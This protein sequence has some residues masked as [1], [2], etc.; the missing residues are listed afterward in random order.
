MCNTR[1]SLLVLLCDFEQ[2]AKQLAHILKDVLKFH[3]ANQLFLKSRTKSQ[4]HMHFK[5]F[6]EELDPD[7]QDILYLTFHQF[8]G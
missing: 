7:Y 3:V 4:N 2:P 1:A 8:A 5:T 6:L